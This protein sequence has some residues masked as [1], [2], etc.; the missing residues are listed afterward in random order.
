MQITGAGL[1]P[2]GQEQGMNLFVREGFAADTPLAVNVAGTAPPP[3]DANAS[4][5]QSQGQESTSGNIQVVPGRLDA[6][7][8]PL[9]GGFAMIFAL[10]GV[11]LGKKP[12]IAVPEGV[13]DPAPQQTAVT[14]TAARAATPS[15]DPA[16][17]RVS[18]AAPG[19][20]QEMDAQ[21][22]TSLDA[23]KERLFRLE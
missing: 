5:A 23:L 22:G 12:V 4:G 1:Q 14:V 19:D 16:T 21:V 13:S 8:W 18:S 20:L 2:S 11:G 9:I 15:P 3:T 6:L 10:G 7:K 17:A